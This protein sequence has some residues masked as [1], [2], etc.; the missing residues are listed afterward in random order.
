MKLNLGTIRSNCSGFEGIAHIADKTKNICYDSIELDFSSCS[1]FEANMAAP[2]Y[3]VIARLRDELNDVTIAN[4]PSGVS[5]ILRKNKFL[6]IF[7]QPD[8]LD[9]NQTTLPFKIFKLHAGEQFNDY[10]DTYMKGRGIPTMSK[11]LTKRF[12]Q[13]LFEIFL[14]ATIHSQ[15]SSGI[16][17]CGQFYPNKHRLDFTIADA[18]VGIRENVRRYTGKATLNSCKAIEWAMTDG[19]TTKTGNQPGGLGLKLIKD[20]I[21]MNGGKIQLVSRFGYYE[22]SANGE[23]IQ[24]MDNDFPGTCINIE[25]NTD[26]T[27]SYCLKSELKNE[28]IF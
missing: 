17:V 26:D 19:N 1:F 18:G 28:D 25:I 5:R 27:G 3:A 11:A 10:L 8:L 13:S 9:I 22:F 12:R 6:S 7:N 15:S 24:K 23:A 14:N 20:F 21:R 4:V 2:L 16:F